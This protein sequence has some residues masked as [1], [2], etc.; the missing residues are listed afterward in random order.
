MEYKY[1]TI[2]KSHHK[3]ITLN[4]KLIKRMKKTL[5]SIAMF[6]LCSGNIF[7]QGAKNIKINEVLT[8]N[9][10]S[11]QD[12]FGERNPWIELVNASYSSYDVRGMFLTTDRK[13]LNKDLSPSQRMSLMSQLPNDDCTRMSARSHLMFFLNSKKT[14]GVHHLDVPI[15]PDG[16]IWIALYDG[17][18]VDLIDSITVPVLNPNTSFAR[19]YD[20]KDIWVSQHEDAVTPGIENYVHV[21]ETK[22]AQL[23]RDDPNGFGITVLSMGIVFSCLLLLYIAFSIVGAIMKRQ[24]RKKEEYRKNKHSRKF[25]LKSWHI[26]R[27]KEQKTQTD[28]SLVTQYK[29]DDTE[30]DIPFEEYMAVIAT[31][32]KQYEDDVHDTESGVITITRSNLHWRN[33]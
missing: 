18:G 9:Q 11:I 1:L 23:K 29:E 30:E 25:H 4:Y 32:I 5:L 14:K 33:V 20:G 10:K 15:I 24:R 6:L 12:E 21:S 31:A 27:K 16:K 7:A 19:E 22:V 17:N 13:A 28:S 26:E 8:I 2:N 3:Q